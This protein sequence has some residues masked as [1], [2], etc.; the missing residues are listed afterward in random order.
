M[1]PWGRGA[2]GQA[3]CR[4][5]GLSGRLIA[6]QLGFGAGGLLCRGAAVERLLS[7]RWAA[8]GQARQE[9]EHQ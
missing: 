3:D 4:A 6:V 5:V 9:K 8:K 7:G 1:G 2:K